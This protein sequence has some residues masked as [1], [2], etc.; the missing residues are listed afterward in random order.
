MT[1]LLLLWLAV[2]GG[3]LAGLAVVDPRAVAPA[4]ATAALLAPLIA[5]AAL[6]CAL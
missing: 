5:A 3:G 1:V 2:A 4:A 6:L